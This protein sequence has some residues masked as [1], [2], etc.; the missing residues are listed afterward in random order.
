MDLEGTASSPLGNDEALDRAGTG[1][2]GVRRAFDCRLADP[3]QEP[4]HRLT[5]GERPGARADEDGADRADV[6]QRAQR[7][8]ELAGEAHERVL[9]E[10]AGPPHAGDGHEPTAVL[11]IR[12]WEVIHVAERSPEDTPACMPRDHEVRANRVA[13]L[14]YAGHRAVEGKLCVLGQHPLVVA[15]GIDVGSDLRHVAPGD[16]DGDRRPLRPRRPIGRCLLGRDY[17]RLALVPRPEVPVGDEILEPHAFLGGEIGRTAATPPLLRLGEDALGLGR[18]GLDLSAPTPGAPRGSARDR[19]LG[20]EHRCLAALQEVRDGIED[21]I[22]LRQLAVLLVHPV[23]PYCLEQP[24][25]V[26]HLPVALAGLTVGELPRCLQLEE[27]R[28][29]PVVAGDVEEAVG[30][31]DLLEI[32]VEGTRPIEERLVHREIA[33]GRPLEELCMVVAVEVDERRRKHLVHPREGGDDCEHLLERVLEVSRRERPDDLVG[34]REHARDRERSSVGRPHHDQAASPPSPLGIVDRLPGLAEAIDEATGDEPT[35]RVGDE[36]N[37]LACAER[38]DLFVE[39]GRA[40]VDVLAPVEGERPHLPARVQ[41]QEDR[42]V[43]RQVHA[44]GSDLDSGLGRLALRGQLEVGDAAED[45]VDEVQPDT[46]GLT[47]AVHRVELGAHDPGQHEDLPQLPAAATASGRPARALERATPHRLLEQPPFLAVELEHD[48]TDGV[49][50][51]SRERGLEPVEPR[52]LRASHVRYPMSTLRA[53]TSSP[54]AK[55][56]ALTLVAPGTP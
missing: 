13:T 56:S 17:R 19:P 35:H 25:R 44:R 48:A 36:V 24:E 39:T 46:V 26:R 41:L 33:P 20:C 7:E 55:P 6:R 23:R 18:D 14:G 2:G 34:A 30:I 37:R 3:S 1:V 40:A 53:A 27:K 54:S 38:L 22:V 52:G 21:V 49:E 11:R 31:D 16:F 28:R 51:R 45:E 43:G 47:R 42:H 32:G 4:A 29:F 9:V 5:D 15:D 12:P 10:R 50:I 8:E